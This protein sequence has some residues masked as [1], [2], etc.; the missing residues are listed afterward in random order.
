M[1]TSGQYV[2]Y[3]NAFLFHIIFPLF[4]QMYLIFIRSILLQNASVLTIRTFV[5][6]MTMSEL[7]CIFT[8]GFSTV[9]GSM[10]AVYK[11]FGVSTC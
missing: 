7:H 9:A 8:S 3:W 1:V 5:S 6:D 11:S 4:A 2:S 10:L